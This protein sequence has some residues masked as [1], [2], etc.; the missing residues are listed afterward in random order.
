MHR[1]I[2][3]AAVFAALA[4]ATLLLVA[5]PASAQEDLSNRIQQARETFRP[6][7]PEQ[8]AEAHAELMQ[9]MQELEQFVRPSTPNGQRWLRYLQWDGLKAELAKDVPPNLNVLDA[10]LERL[11]QNQNGLELPQ[12][13]RLADALE[14][15]RNLVAVSMWENPAELYGQQLDALQSGLEAYRNDPTRANEAALGQR[16]RIINDLGQAP[17]LVSSIRREYARPNAFIDVST[18]LVAAGAEPIDRRERITDNILGTRISGDAHTTGTVDVASIPS[19][20]KAILQFRSRGRSTSQ[21]V[22]HNGPAVIRSSGKT[23][24]TAN[25]QV[26]LS[27]ETFASEPARATATTNSDIHSI[28]KASG[29]LGSRMVS[30]QGWQQARQSHGRADAIAADH[31]E[32]RIERRFN[33][34]VNEQLRDARRRYE[35]EYRQ[36]LE[37]RGEQPE[38]VRFSSDKDSISVEAVQANQGQLGATDEPP[39]EPEGHDLTMRLHESAVNNYSA[40]MLGGATASETEPG[41]DPKFNVELPDWMDRAWRQ[42]KTEPAEDATASEEPFKAWSMK[43]R[44]RPISVDFEDGKVRLTTHVDRLKS[45]DQTFSDWDVTGTYTSELTNGSVILR[46]EGDLEM[47]PADFKGSLSSR[48]TAERRNLEKEI[49]ERSAQGGGFPSTIEFEPI[50]PEGALA[51]AGPLEVNEFIADDGW[52]T[53]AW[54]RQRNPRQASR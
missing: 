4:I 47:L 16:L 37:R 6:V 10:T 49:N 25:K 46:R 36:P 13:R 40:T 17:D 53:I 15:Y 38:H 51:D 27:D 42:R 43:F 48:Q 41:G 18:G 24:F 22:G 33:Q 21:N 34:D 52:L 31:A 23:D 12:F 1:I 20:D 44:D 2:N 35:E 8:L 29:G 30:S 3:P 39:A 14:Q 54:D 9:R 19:D 32:D 45:G 28:A 7:T 11:K 5:K 26:E 50:Q